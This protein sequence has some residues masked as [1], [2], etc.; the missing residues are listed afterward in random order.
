MS[1]KDGDMEDIVT[2]DVGG[3]EFKTLMS[4]LKK[5]DT[6]LRL[7]CGE[8]IRNVAKVKS[9]TIFIDRDPKHFPIILNYLRDQDHY[10]RER[11]ASIPTEE[12]ELAELELE[13]R[14]YGIKEL[15]AYCKD[16]LLNRRSF[17]R[18]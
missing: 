8:E 4:T 6:M 9:G 11:M 7:F 15:V 13:A 5:S 2:V 10:Q 14:F 1:M 17:L 16:P 18:R 12:D 3:T